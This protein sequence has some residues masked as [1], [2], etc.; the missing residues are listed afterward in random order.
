MALP[1]QVITL[2]QQ[3]V[4]AQTAEK[5]KELLPN[6]INHL[7]DSTPAEWSESDVQ[8]MQSFFDQFNHFCL[9]SSE[10]FK[11]TAIEFAKLSHQNQLEFLKN[12]DLSKLES[13]HMAEVINN[14]VNAET[15]NSMWSTLLGAAVAVVGIFG[16]VSTIQQHQ[17][18][19]YN[20]KRPRSLSEKI[21]GDHN[22]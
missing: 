14:K 15:T 16:A 21:F 19:S 4:V 12:F 6:I 20:L 13:Q 11:Q 17:Q 1:P 5:F 2:I 22:R 8:L 10:Q 3:A 18:N 7:N 9:N